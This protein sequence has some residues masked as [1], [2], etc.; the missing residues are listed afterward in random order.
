MK[1]YVS[2]W[3]ALLHIITCSELL[4]CNYIGVLF[5]RKVSQCHISDIG[6]D[7]FPSP[8]ELMNS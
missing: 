6:L 1:G 4:S 5:L 8:F 2:F 3:F 7:T